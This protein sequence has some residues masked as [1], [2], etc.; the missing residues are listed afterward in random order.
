M[1]VP[2]SYTRYTHLQMD[3]SC[4]IILRGKNRSL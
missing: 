3:I 1:V 2:K 4:V